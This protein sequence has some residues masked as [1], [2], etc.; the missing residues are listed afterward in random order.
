MIY[1]TLNFIPTTSSSSTSISSLPSHYFSRKHAAHPSALPTHPQLPTDDQ[2]RPKGLLQGYRL[3]AHGRP[4]KVW[5]IHRQLRSR[6]HILRTAESRQLQGM[7]TQFRSIP[8]F[9]VGEENHDGSSQGRGREPRMIC[10]SR[11]EETNICITYLHDR[12]THS[13]NNH[14][15]HPS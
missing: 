1:Q 12:L 7:Q 6:A 14:S 11:E 4:H 13:C 9:D 10:W 2:A 15:S 8:K 3:W 5:W